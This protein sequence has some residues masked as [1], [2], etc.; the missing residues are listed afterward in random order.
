MSSS[1]RSVSTPTGTTTPDVPDDVHAELRSR[2]A[3]AGTSLSDY[4]LAELE[5]VTRRSDNA[6][7]LLRA[8]Q[9][10]WSVTR[11]VTRELLDEA[12]APR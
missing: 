11:V 8:A 5:R 9:R 10:D 6:E 12:R 1:V 2:A 3:A 4:V 7:V